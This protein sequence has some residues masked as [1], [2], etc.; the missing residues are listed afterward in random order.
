MFTPLTREHNYQLRDR[1]N[2]FLAPAIMYLNLEPDSNGK[3]NIYKDVT[4]AEYAA[5]MNKYL[6]LDKYIDKTKVKQVYT[7]VP[8]GH[9]AYKVVCALSDQV[10]FK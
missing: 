6:E 10:V 9:P 7:D 4:K 5:F 2:I 8:K 1:K 3:Y